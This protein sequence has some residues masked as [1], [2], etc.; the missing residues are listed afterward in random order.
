MSNLSPLQR[1]IATTHE[2]KNIQEIVDHINQRSPLRK[3]NSQKFFESSCDVYTRDDLYKLD[4]EI[5]AKVIINIALEHHHRQIK[6]GHV[7]NNRMTS[8][9]E[10]HSIPEINSYL[11]RTTCPP[12]GSDNLSSPEEDYYKRKEKSFIANKKH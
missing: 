7:I 1:F 9:Y 4:P 8:D 5:R 2:D 11:F 10:S 3:K 6:A 12:Y